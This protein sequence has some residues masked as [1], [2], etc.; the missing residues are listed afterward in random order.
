MD[1]SNEATA[2]A[3]TPTQNLWMKT[4]MIVLTVALLMA[5]VIAYLLYLDGLVYLLFGG[6]VLIN[7]GGGLLMARKPH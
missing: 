5:S 1:S 2:E 4:I 3:A 7:L 6:A